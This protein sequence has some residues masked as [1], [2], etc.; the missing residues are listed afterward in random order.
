MSDPTDAK[1]ASSVIANVALDV[2]ADL[3]P[4]K[5][6]VSTE[7]AVEIM[8]WVGSRGNPQ[9]LGYNQGRSNITFELGEVI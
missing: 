7:A 5:A 1:Y 4:A 3:D 2:F 8:I 6:A 9:P